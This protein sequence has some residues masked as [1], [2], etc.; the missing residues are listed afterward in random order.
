MPTNFEDLL[1]YKI[2]GF[3]INVS[4]IASFSVIRTFAMLAIPIIGK[5][6]YRKLGHIIPNYMKICI[7]VQKLLLKRH[8]GMRI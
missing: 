8:A 1:L 5:E 7:F 2:S 6:K 3:N 4:S